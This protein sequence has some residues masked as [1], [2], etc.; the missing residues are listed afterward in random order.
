MDKYYR[1]NDK[2]NGYYSIQK[3]IGE[4]RYGIA[5][6]AI[7]DKYEKFVIKQLKREMLEQSREKLFYEEQTLRHLDNPK[8]PKFISRFKDYD[9]EGYILEYI[10]GQ[11]IYDLLRKYEY[12]FS[13]SEI[14]SIG[15][16]LIEM[17]EL[18]HSKN[19]VHRDIRPPN[20]VMKANKE[21]ALIDF[22]LARFIDNKRYGTQMD[23][24]YLGDFM[25]YL[26]YSTYR[27]TSPVERPWYEE[28]DLNYD[29]LK[30]LRKL[31]GMDGRYNNMEEIK[32]QFKKIKS[33]Y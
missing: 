13:R 10:D 4:G 31:M 27:N 33:M 9:R 30:L 16:Q 8:F 26:Y 11:V 1:V 15:S 24:W 12:Q 28:L 32:I 22:G 29:E 23:Y 20:V 17:A 19:I 7:N 6:L 18:L 3:M 14:Y 21:L 25:I 2:V 5:Y